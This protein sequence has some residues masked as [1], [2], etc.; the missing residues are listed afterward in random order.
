MSSL[1][2]SVVVLIPVQV[3]G[4]LMAKGVSQAVKIR[5]MALPLSEM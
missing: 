5:N 4:W 2:H 1:C 3:G